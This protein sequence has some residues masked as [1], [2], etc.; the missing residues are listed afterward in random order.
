MIL[1]T[2]MISLGSHNLLGQE[3]RQGTVKIDSFCLSLQRHL[4][5]LE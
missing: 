2:F 5:D 4:G 3:V 1:S